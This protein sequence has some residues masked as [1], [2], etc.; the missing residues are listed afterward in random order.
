VWFVVPLLFAALILVVGLSGHLGRSERTPSFWLFNHRLWL[1]AAL[2]L[3]GAC[4][5][6]G[7]LSIIIETLNFLLRACAALNGTSTRIMRLVDSRPWFEGQEQNPFAEGKTPEQTSRKVLAALSL[8]ADISNSAGVI[9][10]THYS[11][12]PTTVSLGANGHVIGPLVFEGGAPAPAAIPPQSI[13]VEGLGTVHLAVADNILMACV[14]GGSELR[15][16]LMDAARALANP[17]S[18]EQHPLRLKASSNDLKGV[19]L[20]DNLNG[21][22]SYKEPDFNF[23]LIRFWLVLKQTE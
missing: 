1:A 21:S 16:N 7:G 23:S 10:F 18:K 4:L 8:R 13:T 3:I 5:F 17:L 6:G 11:D 2:A 22:Y 12:L 9:Y 19:L 14:E 20:I 15:F